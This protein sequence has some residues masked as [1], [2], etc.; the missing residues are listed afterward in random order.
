MGTTLIDRHI[1]REWLKIFLMTLAAI[2]GLLL[3][4]RIFELAPDFMRWG[5]SATD[6][7]ACFALQ[8]PAY[9]PVV[10]P[11]AILVST[12]FLLC[13]LH[14]DLELTA[15][16]CAG[17]GIFRITR[18]LW[19]AGGCLSVLLFLLNASLVPA[20]TEL[21]RGIME[22][23]KFNFLQREKA[24]SHPDSPAAA[25][26]KPSAGKRPT[27]QFYVNNNAHRIW[28]INNFDGHSGRGQGVHIHQNDEQGNPVEAWLASYGEYDAARGFWT[29]RDGRHLI[30]DTSGRLVA[31]PRFKELPLPALT[32]KPH[33]MLVM[34]LSNK[35][36]QLSIHEIKD[37]LDQAG[38]ESSARIASLS[39]QYH[40]VIASP[41]TCLIAIGL[42]IPFAVAGVRVNPMVGISKSILLFG[43]YHFSMIVFSLFG[44]QRHIPPML[45]AW[46][47]NI[48]MLLLALVLCRRVS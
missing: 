30:Y 20:A 37:V 38:A 9:L 24:A 23:A 3:V 25:D 41:F 32:E 42:A 36:H 48:L 18:S 22:G 39:V 46:L 7:F 47:P 15:M 44:T 28:S 16:R 45:A 29:L 33:T 6:A 1:L 35:P 40:S 34:N 26:T 2:T 17:L 12:L 11:V 27:P 5:A 31:E 14:R 8:V 43:L 4:A 10:L 21:S 19:A 13:Q